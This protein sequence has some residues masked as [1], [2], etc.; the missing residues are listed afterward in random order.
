[1]R[2]KLLA[3][4]LSC[5]ASSSPATQRSVPAD[6]L[7][8]SLSRDVDDGRPILVVTIMNRSTKQIC[9]EA[10]ALRN[11]ET[12]AV[13]VELRDARRRTVRPRTVTGFLIPPLSGAVSIN[14]GNSERAN[15]YLDVR[16][17][18]LRTGTWPRQRFSARISLN[19]R[20]CDDSAPLRATSAWQ[21]I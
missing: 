6:E 19:Y 14:P 5:A 18:L 13:D 11:P 4:V 15:Y 2:A 1:M 7:D 21:P 9:L 16:F 8:I 3:L 12:W 10:D 20:H 17:R